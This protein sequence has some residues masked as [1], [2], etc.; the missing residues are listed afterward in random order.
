MVALSPVLALLIGALALLPSRAFG[1]LTPFVSL[2]AV[3]VS[4]ALLLINAKRQDILVSLFPAFASAPDLDLTFAFEPSSVFIAAIG[5][6]AFL[7]FIIG[8]R[9]S[10]IGGIGAGRLVALA[11]ALAFVL[12][13]NWTTMAAGWLLTDLGLLVWGASEARDDKRLPW[14]AL[15][16]SQFGALIFLAAGAL[17]LN[18]GSSLRFDSAV[19]AGVS[20]DIVFV[21]GWM[22]SRLYPFQLPSSQ[23]PPVSRAN[24]IQR[25]ALTL[26]LGVFLIVRALTMMQG[27]F[28]F[29]SVLYLLALFGAG[30]TAI[31]V[32][33]ETDPKS[34]LIWAPLAVGVPISLAALLGPPEARPA[35]LVWLGVGLFDL[36]LITAGLEYVRSN[37]R[38][39]PF[40]R[41]L[42]GVAIF[43]AAGFPGTPAFLGRVGLYAAAFHTN[44]PLV[45]LAMV[46]ATTL[47]IIPFWTR[48]LLPFDSEQQSSDRLEFA[49]VVLLLIPMLL[50][51]LLPFVLTSFFGRSV[52]DG[53]TFAFDSL[54][55]GGSFWEPIV[56]LG[57]VLLP[58]LSAFL[59]SKRTLETG[60][61]AA[62]VPDGIKRLLDLSTPGRFLVLLLDSL[63]LAARQI[64]ALIEQHPLGWILFAAIW[65]AVWLLNG[66]GGR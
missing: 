45:V 59:I 1:R 2:D 34:N 32:L 8:E 18:L 49:L 14:R 36:I 44:D 30:A 24:R 7:S 43:C 52:E 55:H 28:E 56:L 60:I 12:A 26:L 50:E 58:P 29:S 4:L 35:I 62:G 22:R 40:R 21:A 17:E 5:L 11:G 63:G 42:W 33:G 61:T 10:G 51:G 47:V 15:A 41:I 19:L 48:F 65:V 39:R 38:R 3:L 66:Q 27:E 25:T 13:S 6:I 31:L 54:L 37:S 57:S 9:S 46:A 20:V 23:E 64:S 53:G 16:I